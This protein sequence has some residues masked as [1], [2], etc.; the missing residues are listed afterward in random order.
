M[1][2]AEQNFVPKN[3]LQPPPQGCMDS[4]SQKCP[5]NQ[6]HCVGMDNTNFVYG[7]EDGMKCFSK[8]FIFKDLNNILFLEIKN[9]L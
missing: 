7:L 5:D 3:S 4:L 1:Y 8:P 9:V 6:L 2:G